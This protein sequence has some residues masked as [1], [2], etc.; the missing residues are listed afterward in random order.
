MGEGTVMRYF[1]QQD[2][3]CKQSLYE[4][5]IGLGYVEGNCKDQGYPVEHTGRYDIKWWTKSRRARRMVFEEEGTTMRY[6]IQQDGTC[7]QSL[8]DSA[9]AL[10]YTPGNCAAQGYPNRH[11]NMGMEW[12][13]QSRRRLK[14]SKRRLVFEEE[15]TA[16]R[17][18]I[19]RDDTCKQSLYDSA[20]GLGYVE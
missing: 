15:G 7:K 12:W 17:Y 13:T 16:M 14:N 2:D 11:S 20:I 6:F 5:A 9:T 3:T 1:I 8:Y 4:S 18:F 19:Q 10:G